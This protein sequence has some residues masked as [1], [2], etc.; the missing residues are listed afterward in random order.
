MQW[1]YLVKWSIVINN[2]VEE[3]SLLNELFC[4]ES[5][6]FEI[7]LL[8]HRTTLTGSDATTS[9]KKLLRDYMCGYIHSL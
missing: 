7:L 4:S 6:H 5:T 8:N 9:N 3:S 2:L 1:N